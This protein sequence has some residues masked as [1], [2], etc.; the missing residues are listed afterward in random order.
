M[1]K[2]CLKTWSNGLK[3]PKFVISDL[4]NL[5]VDYKIKTFEIIFAQPKNGPFCGKRAKKVVFD[6]IKLR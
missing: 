6:P 2:I 3:N 5:Y 1:L 4:I